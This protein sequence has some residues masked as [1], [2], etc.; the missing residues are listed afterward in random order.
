MHT[1][2]LSGP[3]EYGGGEDA[4]AMWDGGR[5]DVTSMIALHEVIASVSLADCP[6]GW[7]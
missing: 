6:I 2:V 3:H 4:V 7:L 5:W 1:P